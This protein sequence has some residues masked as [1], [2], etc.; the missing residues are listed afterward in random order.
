ME[1]HPPPGLSSLLFSFYNIIKQWIFAQPGKVHEFLHDLGVPRSFMFHESSDFCRRLLERTEK[2]RRG[3]SYKSNS[4]FLE[5]RSY[6]RINIKY[7]DIS[8][9]NCLN[10]DLL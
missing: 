4:S 10:L 9:I 7:L 1:T 2:R 8:F 6:N 3:S 5:F